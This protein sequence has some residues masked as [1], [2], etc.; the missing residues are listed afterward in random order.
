MTS[1]SPRSEPIAGFSSADTNEE[2]AAAH[3][4]SAIATRASG[5]GG[6][7]AA[8]SFLGRGAAAET[9]VGLASFLARGH[10]DLT[11]EYVLFPGVA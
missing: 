5:R 11:P 10:G 4:A 2:L 3:P 6:A 9:D 7:R 1:G 8:R